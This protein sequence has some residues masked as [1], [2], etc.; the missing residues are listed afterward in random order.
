[1]GAN[2]AIFSMVHA[3]LLHPYDFQDLERLVRVWE[4]RGVD[5]GFDARR[6]LRHEWVVART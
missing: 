3:L 4:Y 2:T 5:E 6:A 1:M